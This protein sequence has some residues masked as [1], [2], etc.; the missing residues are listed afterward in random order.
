MHGAYFREMEHAI[1]EQVKNDLIEACVNN[2]ELQMSRMQTVG[3]KKI[4]IIKETI[5][6]T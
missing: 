1:E 6:N 4:Y 5:N 2:E 3:F